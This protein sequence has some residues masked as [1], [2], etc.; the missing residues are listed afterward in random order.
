MKIDVHCHL[1]MLEDVSAVLKR[2]K[3]K[4]ILAVSAGT[5]VKT[6]RE[7]LNF[8]E[9]YENVF[10]C[11]GVYP[12]DVLKMGEREF[13]K[14]IEFIRKQ[15]KKIIGIG[16]VGM[17]FKGEV[18]KLDRAG[19]EKAF[20]QFVTL[21]LE[22]G[23]PIVVHSRKAEEECI[24]ILEEMKAKKVVMHCFSG[25]FKLVERIVKNGWFLSIPGNVKSL[26]HFQKVI[27]KTSINQL[28]CETDS[29]FLHPDKEFPNTPENVVVSYEEI[30]RI[31]GLDLREV[32][33]VI[34]DNF[35][36]LFF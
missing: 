17:D 28:L 1:E 2:C 5:N 7:V 8:V 32:E 35:K 24:D 36:S 22:L 12:R 9:N 15:G 11:L 30:A 27:E 33:R 6:N 10:G 16:E 13:D 34:E 29:P 26:E 21:S 20:R 31:K 25:N 19:Q 4:N 14:E 18:S 23:K 3:E